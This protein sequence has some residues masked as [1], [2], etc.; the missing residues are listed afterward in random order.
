M[1]FR[2]PV[3]GLGGTDVRFFFFFQ[4]CHI[5]F[6]SRRIKADERQ[7]PGRQTDTSSFLKTSLLLFKWN[8]T[9]LLACGNVLFTTRTAVPY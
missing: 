4:A 8:F 3:P 2:E 1:L 9:P 5:F 7:Q 6:L